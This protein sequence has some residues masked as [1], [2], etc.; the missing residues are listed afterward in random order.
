MKLQAQVFEGIVSIGGLEVG[1]QARLFVRDGQVVGVRSL[2]LVDDLGHALPV[3]DE[4]TIE[5]DPR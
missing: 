5:T 3:Y 2:R 1:L 4:G